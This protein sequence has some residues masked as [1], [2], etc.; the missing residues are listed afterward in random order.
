MGKVRDSTR[1]RY[2]TEPTIDLELD[3]IAHAAAEEAAEKRELDSDAAYWAEAFRAYD[4]AEREFAH[5]RRINLGRR[6][7]AANDPEERQD[8]FGELCSV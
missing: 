4:K 6:L 8:L 2:T 5:E 7:A 1:G 3:Y